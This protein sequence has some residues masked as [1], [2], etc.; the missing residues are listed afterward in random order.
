MMGERGVVVSRVERP[1]ADC[2]RG[3]G[4]MKKTV[5]TIVCVVVGALVATAAIVFGLVPLID[6]N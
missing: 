6:P 2:E 1:M 4:A 5:S 3:V